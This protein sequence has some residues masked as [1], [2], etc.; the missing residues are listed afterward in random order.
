MWRILS[1]RTARWFRAVFRVGLKF[2]YSPIKVT[3]GRGDDEDLQVRSRS[4]EL[5]SIPAKFSRFL[6]PN[7]PEH[8]PLHRKLHLAKSQSKWGRY[9]DVLMIFISLYA[10]ATYVAE[11]Y[12]ADYDAV[13]VYGISEIVVTQFFAVDFLYNLASSPVWSSFLVA[14]WTIV[15][16]LTIVPVYISIGL[17]TQGD[18]RKVVNLSVLRFIRIL[19]LVRILRMF[20]LL[21]GMSG[22]RRQLITLTLTLLSL[23]F[24]AAGIMQ[25]MENDVR[26]LLDYQCLYIGPETDWLP[27]CDPN[28]PPS[29]MDKCDCALNNCESYYSYYDNFGAPSNVRCRRLTFLSSF[30]YILVTAATIGYGDIVPTSEVSRAVVI[31][32]IFTT[33]TVI[34]VQVNSLTTLLSMTSQYRQPYVKQ[35]E[36]H[37]VICGYVQDWRKL[38]DFLKEILHPDRSTSGGGG[39]D[40]LHVVILSPLEPSEDLKSLLILSHFDGRV[41]YLVGSALNMS[42]LQRV[43]ADAAVAMFF[44]CNPGKLACLPPPPARMFY[45]IYPPNT[46]FLTSPTNSPRLPNAILY[47]TF[48]K[49]TNLH[50]S[51]TMQLQCCEHCP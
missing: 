13:Q 40:D 46:L 14:P 34:P 43:R 45:I 41:T 30:Y 5:R 24:M 33:M 42:D 22:V 27:S 37:V 38:E 20:K 12:N 51:S 6:F 4:F 26:Q 8:H 31:F 17:S 3:P 36:D 7:V 32:I 15:D 11:Q 18:N 23:L 28:L 21:N 19:R 35:S 50:Q 39:D 47:L 9:W 2:L 44:M 1:P 48:Q 16:M 29:Q 25:F 49:S 10:C